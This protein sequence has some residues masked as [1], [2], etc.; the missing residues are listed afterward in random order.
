[1][2]NFEWPWMLLI[3]PL[4]WLVRRYAGPVAAAREAALRVPFLEE[5]RQETAADLHVPVK[6]WPLWLAALAWLLL[7]LAAMRPLWLGDFIDIPVSGRDLMLA[8]DLSGSM[9]E[10]DFIIK[11]EQVDRLSA[12]K[13]VAGDFIQRRVGD[14]LGLILFGEQAYLQAPLTFDHKTVQTLLNESA[15][16]LAGKATAIGDAIGL[17]AYTPM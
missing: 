15:I 9:E 14:R 8:V 5:F 6:N 2:I 4:P 17:A 7:V 12:T 13:W 3:L 1:M 10:E 16:G 11:G